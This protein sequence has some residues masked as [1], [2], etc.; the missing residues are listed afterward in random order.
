MKVFTSKGRS[1]NET[2]SLLRLQPILKESQQLTLEY[3]AN[4]L[5]K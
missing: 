1:S 4:I 3:K 5:Q 2:Q